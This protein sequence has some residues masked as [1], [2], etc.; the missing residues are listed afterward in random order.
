MNDITTLTIY[1]ALFS[2][3]MDVTQK[4]LALA[5]TLPDTAYRAKTGCAHASL[6]HTFAHLL[7]ADYMWRNVI[8]DT[9]LEYPDPDSIA[10]IDAL[11]AMLT[12]ERDGWRRLIDGYDAVT[13]NSVLERESPDG[14]RHS[15]TVWRTMMHVILHGMQHQAELA[16]MLTQAGCDPGDISFLS[17]QSHL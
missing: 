11:E 14:A 3:H 8:A 17:H 15:F 16:H 6:H 13:I 7:S 1:H 5:H 4:L 12:V 9:P 2:F 10:G